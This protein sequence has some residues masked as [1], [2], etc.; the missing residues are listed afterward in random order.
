MKIIFSPSKKQ[1][2][3]L[4]PIHKGVER[5]SIFQN[6]TL[7]LVQ[8]MKRFSEEELQGILKTSDTIT[9]G[10]FKIYQGFEGAS[11]GHALGSF[12]GTAFGEIDASAFTEIQW[13][14]AQEH[15]CILSGLYGVLK[16]LDLISEYRLDM[17]DKVFQE[18]DTHKNLYDFW[19][20]KIHGYFEGEEQILNLASGE[21]SKMLS[22]EQR[23]R[24]ITVDFLI[25]KDG[26]VKSVSVFAKQQRGKMLNWIIENKVEN[27]EEIDTYQSDGFVFHEGLSGVKRKVFVR[28]R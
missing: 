20:E 12:R 13:K 9:Q 24:M 7:Q 23:Q 25:Q 5:Q 3:N 18:N 8:R 19:K 28:D 10:V 11:Y 17:N 15:V 27:F 22:V 1:K 21:Y 26:Q 2:T 14:F 16:P 4:V 6:S